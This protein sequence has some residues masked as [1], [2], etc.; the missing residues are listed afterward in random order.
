MAAS[1]KHFLD[2]S[3][4]L[5]MSGAMIGKPAGVFT[6]TAS[7]H[8][9]HE[10]TLLTMMIPLLHHGMIVLGL[11]YNET[12]LRQTATGG[13]PYGASRLTTDN[14][15]CTISDDEK[16]LCLALGRRIAETAKQLNN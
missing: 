10:S 4:S 16:S 8:G 12:A 3:G 7:M 5:W 11:P 2:G 1:L 13:T 6:A 15:N 9:G 14:D